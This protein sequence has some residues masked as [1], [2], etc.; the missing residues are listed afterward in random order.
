MP[1]AECASRG[2]SLTACYTLH[3]DWVLFSGSIPQDLIAKCQSSPNKRMTLPQATKKLLKKKMAD[4]ND[5]QIVKVKRKFT[6]PRKK[7]GQRKEPAKYEWIGM[8]G[9]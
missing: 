1:Q 7:W 5:S 3:R 9:K 8:D 2:K 6:A 4:C